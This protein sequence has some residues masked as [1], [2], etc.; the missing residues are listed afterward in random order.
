M[1]KIF[2]Y[3]HE[4]TPEKRMVELYASMWASFVENG[5]PVPNNNEAF[6]GVTWDRFVQ[7]NYL[8]IN[9]NSTMKTGLYSD[10]M[11]EWEN[12][13]PLSLVSEVS[14]K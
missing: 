2:P 3:F 10:R 5:E 6:R 14:R 13:F 4:F 9:L 8:E 1:E 11:K 12:L 7:N